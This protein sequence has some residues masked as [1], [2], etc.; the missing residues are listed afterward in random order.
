MQGAQGRG[1]SRCGAEGGL[2]STSSTPRSRGSPAP[3]T[4]GRGH[5]HHHPSRRAEGPTPPSSRALQ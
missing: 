3:G 2:Q 4:P 1:S 5:R